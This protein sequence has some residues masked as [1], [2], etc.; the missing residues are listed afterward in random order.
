M[1][2]TPEDLERDSFI[3]STMVA[4]VAN[5]QAAHIHSGIR[6]DAPREAAKAMLTTKEIWKAILDERNA[7]LISD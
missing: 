6:F 2:K 3:K 7:N 4:I 5:S 1:T